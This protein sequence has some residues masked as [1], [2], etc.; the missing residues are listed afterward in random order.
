[1][2]ICYKE[3]NVNGYIIRGLF[4]EPDNGY[5]DI[6]VM[7]HGYTG[8]KNENGF[9]FKQ[10]TKTLVDNNIAT[11]RFDYY[12]SGDSDGEF[13]D[14]T[15]TTV[16]ND[17]KAVIDEAVKLNNGKQIYLIGFSMGGAC[18]ARMSVERKD[19]IKKLVLMSP[20]GDMYEILNF[21]FTKNP[22]VDE[23]FVDIGGYYVGKGFLESFKDLNMYEGLADFDKPVLITQG[24]A[25]LSVYPEVSKKYT[26]YYKDVKYVLIDGASHCYTKVPYRKQVNEEIKNFLTK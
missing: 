1:M 13:K 21:V 4:S 5:T 10:I 12:G 6:A 19:A 9:L 20:A 16:R 26:N 2:K 23:N 18:A 14:Q 11:L 24:S 22:V 7:L 15:F 8:H 25:D 17:A 3:L